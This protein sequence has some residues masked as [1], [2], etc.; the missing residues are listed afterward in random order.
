MNHQQLHP[1]HPKLAIR[2]TDD[3][4]VCA[5]LST[6]DDSQ[7][8]EL[9]RLSVDVASAHKDLFDRWVKLMTAVMSAMLATVDLEVI[10]T[11]VVPLAEKD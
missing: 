5:Y 7:R 9:G 6:V 2:R 4:W 8:V 11:Y 10:G 1:K 3:N